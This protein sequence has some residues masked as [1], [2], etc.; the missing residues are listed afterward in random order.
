MNAA[1]SILVAALLASPQAADAPPPASG[2]APPRPQVHSPPSPLPHPVTGPAAVATQPPPGP[3]ASNE[4]LAQWGKEIG[5]LLLKEDTDGI[6]E[7]FAPSL[8]A[9]LPPWR[10][11]QGWGGIEDRNG[12]IRSVGEAEVKGSG[13]DAVVVLPLQMERTELKAMVAFNNLGKITSIRFAPSAA[14][15]IPPAAEWRAPAYVNPKKFRDVDVRL[16]YAPWVLVGALSLPAGKGPFPAVVLVHGSGPNDQD[17]TVGGVKPFRDLAWGLASQGVAVLRYEKRTRTYGEKMAKLPVTVK[18]EVL[19]DA[20]AAVD[21]LRDNDAIDKGRI[22]VLGHSLGGQLAPRI[23]AAAKGKVAGVVVMAGPT[24]PLPDI[25][26]DQAAYLV[27]NG[28]ATDEVVAPLRA[29]AKKIRELD[30]AKP[31]EGLLLNAPAG[32][33]IDLARYDAVGTA[34][35]NALPILVLQ[36]DRDYMV[37]AKDLDG[38]KKGLAGAPFARFETFPEANHLFVNGQGKSLPTEYLMAGN[39]GAKVVDVIAE[40]VKGLPVRR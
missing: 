24:R 23:A 22:V 36:G 39:V 33:W 16:G 31:P 30:P 14:P 11:G 10:F 4:S 37:T 6:A 34:R 9:V 17:E 20:V 25:V 8:V 5:A 1:V 28:A 27:A 19:D 15:A 35:S 21:F 32:Y 29:D 13:K 26:E 18:E 7:R 3:P 12:K 2:V 40:W 38:W